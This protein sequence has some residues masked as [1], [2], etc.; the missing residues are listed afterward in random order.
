MIKL[1]GEDIGVARARHPGIK[2][3]HGKHHALH[4]GKMQRNAGDQRQEGELDRG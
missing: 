2:H 4:P 1:P 3:P